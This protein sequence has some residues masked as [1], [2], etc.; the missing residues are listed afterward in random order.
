MS[1]AN[2][3]HQRNDPS[4][5]DEKIPV[6][7]AAKPPSDNFET[8]DVRC[9][10]A[11]EANNLNDCVSA[12]HCC[13]GREVAIAFQYC[14]HCGIFLRENNAVVVEINSPLN[15]M[16]PKKVTITSKSVIVGR[17]PSCDLV[18]E[19]DPNLS[20]EHASLQVVD[21]CLVV[22]NI[23]GR[24]GTLLRITKPTNLKEGDEVVVGSHQ[25]RVMSQRAAND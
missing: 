3:Q 11:Q 4:Q 1:E 16:K 20:R 9:T 17:A 13:C 14:P 10:A 7:A 6:S 2:G 18:I 8:D 19:G 25:L 23:N 5:Q 22:D 21:G 24:N 15:N 12:L